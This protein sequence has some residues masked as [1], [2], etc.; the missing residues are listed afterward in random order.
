MNINLLY[1]KDTIRIS[2]PSMTWKK[3]YEKLKKK[4]L[5]SKALQIHQK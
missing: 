5:Y 2:L 1:F 3:F 4:L